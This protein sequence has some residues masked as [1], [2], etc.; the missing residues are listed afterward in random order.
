M[1]RS[2]SVLNFTWLLTI[3][4][5]WWSTLCECAPAVLSKPIN[6]TR[7]IPKPL[8]LAAG[9][10][11]PPVAT[12]ITTVATIT[13]S[14]LEFQL[15]TIKPSQPINQIKQLSSTTISLLTPAQPESV[16]IEENPAAEQSNGSSTVH[17]KGDAVNAIVSLKD[18][19][20]DC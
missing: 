9:T 5:M 7:K 15:G 18:A 11:A 8:S 16:K 19:D 4:L 14:P 10:A 13:P 17:K 2:L 20:C 1:H 12:D 3:W 6:A